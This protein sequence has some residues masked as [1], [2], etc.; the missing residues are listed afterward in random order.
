MLELSRNSNFSEALILPLDPDETLSAPHLDVT[1]YS[2]G[3]YIHYFL[4]TT[5]LFSIKFHRGRAEHRKTLKVYLRA[6]EFLQVQVIET[7]SRRVQICLILLCSVNE[8]TISFSHIMD[9]TVD[10]DTNS[11]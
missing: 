8:L 11:N 1:N 5:I 10:H 2:Q 3:N 9:D 4:F 6:D 7:S